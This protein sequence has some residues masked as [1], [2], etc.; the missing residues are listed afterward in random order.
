ML[1]DDGKCLNLQLDFT[2][3]ACV[4]YPESS[5]SP[6]SLAQPLSITVVGISGGSTRVSGTDSKTI[7]EVSNLISETF[8]SNGKGLVR[9]S[10][11][12][13]GSFFTH[14]KSK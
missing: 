11:T 4:L 3:K 5:N 12:S 8:S 10:C 6:L 9:T 14:K 2:P 13:V 1:S 7:P